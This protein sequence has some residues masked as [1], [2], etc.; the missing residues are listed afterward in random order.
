MP[1]GERLAPGEHGFTGK[2]RGELRIRHIPLLH[3]GAG[4]WLAYRLVAEE[5]TVVPVLAE[6]LTGGTP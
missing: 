2:K 1:E 3:A 6:L 5:G 4:I